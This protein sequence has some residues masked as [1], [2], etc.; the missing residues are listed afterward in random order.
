MAQS[1]VTI[2]LE[3]LKMWDRPESG[4]KGALILQMEDNVDRIVDDMFERFC[5]LE[6]DR[7][8]AFIGN[9]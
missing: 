4:Q 3:N 5:D 7:P 2:F 8:H 6:L 1:D 9:C